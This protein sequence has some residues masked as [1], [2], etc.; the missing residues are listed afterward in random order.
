MF[1]LDAVTN[2]K[3]YSYMRESKIK[4][5]NVFICSYVMPDTLLPL[6]SVSPPPVIFIIAF[7]NKYLCVIQRCNQ[8]NIPALLKYAFTRSLDFKHLNSQNII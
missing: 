3:M 1:I 8:M 6:Q 4:K 5:Q 2:L 7:T